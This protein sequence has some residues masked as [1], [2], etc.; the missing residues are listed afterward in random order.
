M[1][2]K[3]AN[4]FNDLYLEARGSSTAGVF[5]GAFKPP[6]KGH[7]HTALQAALNGGIDTL[8][9]LMSDTPRTLE[10]NNT[11][12]NT[13]DWK[14]YSGLLP[15]GR[16]HAEFD[17]KIQIELA[18]CERPDIGGKPASASNLRAKITQ[19]ALHNQDIKTFMDNANEF[20]PPELAPEAKVEVAKHMVKHAQDGIV[21]AYEAAQIWEKYY[22]P[23][24]EQHGGANIVFEILQ[25]SPVGYT[26]EVIRTMVEMQTY[27]KVKLFVGCEKKTDVDD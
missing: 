7:Y 27:D 21:D 1:R 15:G 2:L 9:I 20:I 25:G 5:P 22:I 6:H 19:F 14:R 17:G 4:N 11:G 26:Y 10:T 24:I 3:I 23:L 18:E 12:N 16:Q 8:F 13:P